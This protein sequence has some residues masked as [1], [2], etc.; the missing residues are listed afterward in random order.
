MT[1]DEVRRA[2]QR[3]ADAKLAR[4]ADLDA[5]ARPPVSAADRVGA[6]YRAGDR[7]LDLP[8][9]REGIVDRVGAP[10]RTGD[11]MVSVRFDDGA[12]GIRQPADL[13]AR[14]RPPS[15]RP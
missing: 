13:L 8:S 4:R 14:P 10:D 9:G 3:I 12:L 1:N 5:A 2:Q 6:P 7:V 11:V 15:S